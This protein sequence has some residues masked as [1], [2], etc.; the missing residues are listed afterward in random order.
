MQQYLLQVHAKHIYSTSRKY[1]SL[2]QQKNFL[3]NT[4]EYFKRSQ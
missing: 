2:Q 3:L 1:T 4:V